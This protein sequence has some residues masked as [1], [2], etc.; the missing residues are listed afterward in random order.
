MINKVDLMS[1][2]GGYEWSERLRAIVIDVVHNKADITEAI[3]SV[4]A[5]PTLEPAA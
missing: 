5:E 2:V 1:S 4:Q 3:K